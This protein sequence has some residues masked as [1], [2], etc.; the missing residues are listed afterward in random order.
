MKNLCSLI[1]GIFLLFA[2]H[3]QTSFVGKYES[4]QD[5]RK[6]ITTFKNEDGDVTGTSVFA[7]GKGAKTIFN[8]KAHGNVLTGK[9]KDDV[10]GLAIKFV[11]TD[12]SGSIS[13]EMK[14]A[15]LELFYTK[16]ER[17]I[18][19]SRAEEGTTTATSMVDNRLVG[20]WVHRQTSNSANGDGSIQE[21]L[22]LSSTGVCQRSTMVNVAGE[23][24]G[25]LDD[26]Q[27]NLKWYVEGNKLY[28]VEHGVATLQG[29]Y[30][31]SN[32]GLLLTKDGQKKYYSKR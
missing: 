5:G 23:N 12:N 22:N 7:D 19:M 32:E 15:L 16:E 11:A 24:S 8:G 9:Q 1:T 30:T 18:T 17:T 25:S 4:E 20:I 26:W 2:A 21:G 13:W 27:D 10:I 14:G 3:S 31:V 28:I 6:L 29:S